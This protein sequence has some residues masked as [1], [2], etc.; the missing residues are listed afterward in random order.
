VR[1][2]WDCGEG[3]EWGDSDMDP[4]HPDTGDT[5]PWWIPY[6]FDQVQASVKALLSDNQHFTRSK[7]TCDEASDVNLS[8]VVALL[9]VLRYRFFESEHG[10]TH[11]QIDSFMEGLNLI[12]A[13]KEYVINRLTHEGLR[14]LTGIKL[15][16]DGS[17]YKGMW[18]DGDELPTGKWDT[19]GP[20][21]GNMELL[22]S[23][24][25]V[26]RNPA[27]KSRCRFYVTIEV[28]SFWLA[29]AGPMQH[30][31]QEHVRHGLS[32]TMRCKCTARHKEGRYICNT[33][34]HPGES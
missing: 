28:V 6:D 31:T 15:G 11:D 1:S 32:V 12:V 27:S 5:Y 18:Q 2:A 7:G 20:P 19:W 13:E 23:D 21:W 29:T 30:G 16:P 4:E 33:S 24:R 10:F 25:E 8:N 3:G 9:R 22:E 34:I 26:M 17:A 14:I